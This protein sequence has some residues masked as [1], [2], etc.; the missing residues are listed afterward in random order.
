[1]FVIYTKESFGDVEV[2][3]YADG[4]TA[5]ARAQ[6]LAQS[7]AAAPTPTRFYVKKEA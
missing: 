7:A 2:S 3:R 6:Q 4:F 1:M 5:H